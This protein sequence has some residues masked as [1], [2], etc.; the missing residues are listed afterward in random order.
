MMPLWLAALIC[1]VAL[2]T[3]TACEAA[4]TS[5][6]RIRLRHWAGKRLSGADAEELLQRPRALLTMAF[7][8]S[9]LS[10]VGFAVTV[11]ALL[12]S[13][14]PMLRD[15]PLL[16]AFAAVA[17]GT[18]PA[19]LL[20]DVLPRALVHEH[21]ARLLP[22]L[23]VGGRLLSVLFWPYTA[24][25]NAVSRLLF[26]LLG[27]PARPEE[28][29]FTASSVETLLREGEREGVVDRHER[30]II[31]GIFAFGQTPIHEVMT[32]RTD[33]VAISLG[34]SR[35]D[36]A[37]RIWETGFSRFPV[38]DG[39]ADNVV[40]IIHAVDVLKAREGERLRIRRPL[41][42]PETTT[43]DELLYTMR[44][45]RIQ[46]AVAVDEYGGIAGIVT[47]EDLVE[48][49]VGDI[50]GEHDREAPGS[51][52]GE[53]L[54][55]D[56]R[57]RLSALRRRVAPDAPDEAAPDGDGSEA[58]TDADADESV[59]AHLL[60]RLGRV[61]VRGERITV[62]DLEIE[63]VQAT[64]KRILRV[65]VTEAP[66]PSAEEMRESAGAVERVDGDRA[67]S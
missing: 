29:Q 34:A 35:R 22:V 48:E 53:G 13:Y 45:Q 5:V 42:V 6:S 32:P 9:N 65:R 44:R 54:L 18:P 1:L 62:G 31:G 25:A 4:L 15:T 41:F 10:I 49:L 19:V 43:C 61:P 7:V 60:R 8:G 11:T 39:S 14:V 67:G 36:T 26:R 33:V 40:G 23:V 58:E 51:N 21:P 30:E 37:R 24:L 20:G 3:F 50:R 56:A 38:T 66:E 46:L 63:V 55:I 27:I 12:V 64:P 52:G 2:A 47:M 16:A 17:L 28:R 57:T 59:A